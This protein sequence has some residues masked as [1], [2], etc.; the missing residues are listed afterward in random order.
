MRYSVAAVEQ[1]SI[2]LAFDEVVLTFDT[3]KGKLEVALGIEEGHV[4]TLHDQLRWA[5]ERTSSRERDPSFWDWLR[6]KL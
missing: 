6:G 5:D 3:D 2:H 1:V 4:K